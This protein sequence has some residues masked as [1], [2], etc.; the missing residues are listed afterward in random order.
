MRNLDERIAAL[1]PEQREKLL[2]KLA[3]QTEGQKNAAIIAPRDTS[4]PARLSFAQQRLWLSHQMDPA[5]GTY[6]I[7]VGL[8]VNG[9]LD[10]PTLEQALAAVVHR[11]EVLRTRYAVV[12]GEPRQFVEPSVSVDIRHHDLES[13]EAHARAAETRRIAAAAA[14]EPFDLSRAPILRAALIRWSTSEA[15]LILVVHHVA[16][17]GWSVGIVVEELCEVY[18]SIREGRKTSLRSLPIQYADF[19]VWQRDRLQGP[20]LAEQVEYWR[21]Q[22][23]EAPMLQLATDRPRQA[24]RSS[25]GSLQTRVI[26]GDVIERLDSLAKRER[27]TQTIVVLAMFQALFARYTGQDD[28]VI[29][30]ALA[31]RTVAEIE[32]LVGC[33][34]NM[35]PMRA[36]LSGD[37]S[38]S[39]VIARVR[40]ASLQAYD[41]QGLPFEKLVEHLNP[42]REPG[43]NPFFQVVLSVHNAPF[44]DVT[45]REISIQ[46]F[47]I[48]ML[49]SRFDI[50]L[51]VVSTGAALRVDIC[52]AAELFDAA[53]ISSILE[54]FERLLRAAVADPT[55]RVAGVRLIDDAT[56]RQVVEEWNDTA[57]RYPRESG[58]PALVERQAA[59]QPAAI[60]IVCEDVSVTYGELNDRANR[61]AHYLRRHGV[62]RG[63]RVGICLERGAD[64]VVG[65]LAILKSGASY[66]PLDPEYPDQRLAAMLDDSRPVVVVSERRLMR[67]LSAGAA[68]T[69]H[70]DAERDAI[71][72]ESSRNLELSI[73]GDDIAYVMYTSGS[74]G[75]PKGVCVPHRAVI[76]LVW[77]ANFAPLDA[78]DVIAQVSNSSFDA[79]TFEIWGALVNGARLAVI[80]RESILVPA[81]LSAAL[82]EN[83]VTAM[84]LTTALFNQVAREQPAAFKG[85]RHLV[86]GGD[87]LDPSAIR[88]VLET[89]PPKRL[90][91]GYGPTE[92]TTFSACFEAVSVAEGATSIPIGR[93][94][95]NSTVYVLD[96][97]F[98]P[99]APGVPGEIFVGGD[100]LAAG[101]LD[102][103]A[104]TAETFLPSPFG[105]GERLYRTGDLGRWI[106]GGYVDFMGRTDDQVKIRGFRIE[107]GEV[108]ATLCQH[109]A[110]SS[111]AVV[112]DGKGTQKR[113]VAYVTFKASAAQTDF[114]TIRAYLRDRVPDYMVP[115]AFVKLD[116]LPL[117]PNGKIDRRALPA[118]VDDEA[119]DGARVAPRTE[120]EQKV[121]AIWR[122]VLATASVG[123][124]DNF[125]D[126]GGH[127]LLLVAVHAR[128]EQELSREIPIVALFQ[129]PTIETFAAHLAS[130]G[131]TPAVSSAVRHTLRS[132]SSES[133]AIAIVGLAGRFPGASDIDTFWSNLR[134]G[135]ESIRS[136]TDE[137]LRE[138]GIADALLSDPRYVKAR[139]AM[140]DVDKFDAAFFGYTP[141]EAELMD[142]Q[143]RLFLECAW[144][145][146]ESTGCDPHRYAGRVGVYAGAKAN[147]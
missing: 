103:P 52:Y 49:V 97:H 90:V 62:A 42:H 142:P 23:H 84:F 64:M 25:A 131:S 143:H 144:H 130:D 106:S 68:R 99:A 104:L 87:A 98:E 132:A 21:E 122:D 138:S 12:D 108:A 65:V 26:A 70:L 53:F 55:A 30:S 33:F 63:A 16:C 24:A 28:I 136:F 41:H 3:A 13:T 69:I 109:A 89:A 11:H 20:V 6:N 113:L 80:A 73:A 83:G 59:A 119:G 86:V 19:A 121:A 118:P 145:A 102:R 78:S 29:G 18:A 114:K 31:N 88:R 35:L 14:V 36:D 50:E 7:P 4:E 47:E 48:P 128:L 51:H 141:R 82:R 27:A 105:R 110:V 17:D 91:N 32:P 72:A 34:V 111:A 77:H 85:V 79:A 9:P 133:N 100:G 125:F 44:A 95:T 137:E 38:F 126:V 54:A 139:G 123:I 134:D 94:I 1:S 2:A 112:V 96:S 124:S 66:V 60:A 129:H 15:V 58:I 8:H 81:A 71:S 92:N 67:P 43:E 135:V 61:L 127:S 93:G 22:L 140:D 39:Q 46:P 37:P 56:R 120:L 76:R 57:A 74:T 107:P 75:K 116:G 117:T 115:S 146:L 10:L 40:E 45:G 5:E 101:Y 147:S